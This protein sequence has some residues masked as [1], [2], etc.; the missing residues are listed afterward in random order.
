METQ[1]HLGQSYVTLKD[2]YDEL[3]KDTRATHAG[4]VK[5]AKYLRSRLGREG[6]K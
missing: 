5:L 2:H 3:V 6:G 4:I 1:A